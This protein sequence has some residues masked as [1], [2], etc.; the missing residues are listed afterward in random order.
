MAR[1]LEKSVIMESCVMIKQWQED[2]DSFNQ[3]LIK[4]GYFDAFL[5]ILWQCVTFICCLE[6][7]MAKISFEVQKKR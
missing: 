1:L 5:G 3:Y 7:Q 2:D 6:N 4:I